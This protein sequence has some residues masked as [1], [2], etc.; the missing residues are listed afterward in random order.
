M[1]LSA[2]ARRAAAP[3]LAASP[4][5]SRRRVLDARAA[6][7]AS[8]NEGALQALF[9]FDPNAG[10]IRWADPS[11]AERLLGAPDLARLA[12]RA[13]F[14][15]LIVDEA[16]AERAAAFDGRAETYVCQYRLA[17]DGGAHWVEERG[18]W[19]GQGDNRRLI[20]IVRSIEAQKKREAQ[21]AWLAVNDELTGLL[22]RAHLRREMDAWLADAKQTGRRGAYFLAGIDD[23]GA[24]NSDYGFEIADEVIVEISARLASILG[25]DDSIGRVAG[26]KFGLLIANAESTTLR[27]TCI[28]LMNVVRES[29]I[30]TRRGGV[31]ASICIGAVDLPDDAEGSTAAMARAEA[32]LDQ[33]KRLGRSSWSAFSEKTDT[34]SMRRR[35]THMSD[36]IL[37][38]LNERRVRLAFQPIVSDLGEAPGK[39]ECLIRMRS[40][41]G[42]EVPAPEFI[43]VAERLGLVHLLDRRVLELAVNTLAISPHIQLAVNISMETVKD[44]VWAEGYLAHLRANA[45]LAKR[46]TVELTETQV[47]DAVDASIEFVS[48]VKALGSSFAIDDFGAGYTSFRNLKALDI[49]ILKIDGS[50]VTG[51]SSSRENQLFVRTLLDLARNFGMKTVAEWVDNEADAMLLKGLGV[52]YLQGYLIGKPEVNPSWLPSGAPNEAPVQAMRA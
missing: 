45:A 5:L 10:Q 3:S 33:A 21:L 7:G 24:V 35:N 38:A 8:E 16:L 40:E 49:D 51:V 15:E 18:G 50:F 26:T 27:E 20:S 17:R 9:E 43:P 11:A 29:V 31:S 28:K 47:I 48:E 46:I 12:D 36:V 37:T 2:D 52:D 34:V 23:L 42:R 39:Y 44:P 30:E 22:N 4:A 19:I 1:P 14:E 32:A 13:A 41:D 25:P 6:D